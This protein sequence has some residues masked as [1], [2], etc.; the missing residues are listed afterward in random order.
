MEARVK[1][2]GIANCDTVKKAKAWLDNHAIAFEFHDY[3]KQ[4][5]ARNQLRAWI[6]KLGW[7]VLLNR[8][9]STWRNLAEETRESLDRD[10]AIRVMLDNPAVIKRPLL[11]ND[12]Q[13][14]LG[15]DAAQYEK[16]LA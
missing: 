9:G 11:D 2:Y 16:N 13:L 1:L 3:R 7:E 15:F 14:I 5:L 12:G 6:D 10:Q 4:G 8:R